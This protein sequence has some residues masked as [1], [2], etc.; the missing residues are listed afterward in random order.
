MLDLPAEKSSKTQTCLKSRFPELNRRPSHYK[1]DA[2]T[3]MLNRLCSCWSLCKARCKALSK[4]HVVFFLHI[5][6]QQLRGELTTYLCA[7]AEL[8]QPTTN[9][10]QS[11]GRLVGCSFVFFCVGG[12]CAAFTVLQASPTDLKTLQS[13]TNEQVQS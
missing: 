3:T 2:I 7:K 13:T 1:C 10:Q 11:C 5:S 12:C 4:T 6:I 8:Q 9:N